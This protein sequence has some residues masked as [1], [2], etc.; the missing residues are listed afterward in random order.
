MTPEQR[1]KLVELYDLYQSLSS[2]DVGTTAERERAYQLFRELL[3]EAD[4]NPFT[5][6]W[7]V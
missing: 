6:H 3:A 2:Y 7:A 4:H 5:D 1:K